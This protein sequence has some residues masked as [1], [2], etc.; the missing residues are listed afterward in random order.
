MP[1]IDTGPKWK[2][3]FLFT[4]WF[5]VQMCTQ[6]V[7]IVATC[8]EI[9]ELTSSHSSQSCSVF[10]WKGKVEAEERW[11]I[12]RGSWVLG[13][14]A[15]DRGLPIWVWTKQAGCKR[16]ASHRVGVGETWTDYFKPPCDK[17]A[18]MN[19]NGRWSSREI[20]SNFPPRAARKNFHHGAKRL[21][22]WN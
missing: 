21:F 2:K 1:H 11:F 3:H 4:N 14:R 16:A 15:E 19:R 7:Q 17:S 18:D 13:G 9:Q 22:I 8:G 12:P 5:C 20:Q 6:N 10:F